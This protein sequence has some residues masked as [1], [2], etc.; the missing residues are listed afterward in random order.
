L[1]WG[2][3]LANAEEP[4]PYADDTKL[5]AAAICYPERFDVEGLTCTLPN[6]DH[7][8]FYQIVPLTGTELQY[9]FNNDMEALEGVLGNVCF[10]PIDKSRESLI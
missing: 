5:C 8:M 9:K 1:G 7:V 2:H 3:T 10:A 4:E 6:G